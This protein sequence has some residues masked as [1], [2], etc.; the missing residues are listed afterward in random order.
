[1]YTPDQ[2]QHLS[3]LHV[4]TKSFESLL[5][6]LSK[7]DW[8]VDSNYDLQTCEEDT[9]PITKIPLLCGLDTYSREIRDKIC[10]TFTPDH[11]LDTN[12]VDT[13]YDHS[14]F[15]NTKT[16]NSIHNQFIDEETARKFALLQ[17]PHRACVSKS[18]VNDCAWDGSERNLVY[19]SK[20]PSEFSY[21][22][23]LL[24]ISLDHLQR[25]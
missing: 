25:F 1:M 8:I 21:N 11:N 16:F 9:I 7:Q 23:I 12:P 17:S 24:N 13:L 3:D 14:L 19:F 15:S 4:T 6:W 10:T 22:A 18:L 5:Q 20:R 2:S